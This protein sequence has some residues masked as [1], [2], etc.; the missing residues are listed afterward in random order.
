MTEEDRDHQRPEG[1]D[2]ATVAAAGKLAEALEW[3]ERARGRLYDFHQ[4]VG[5]P[6]SSSTKRP[7]AS[8]RPAT[9]T[10]PTASAPT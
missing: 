9:P 4:L 10:W 7:T 1:V 5:T 8:I 2:D 3:I 6:T